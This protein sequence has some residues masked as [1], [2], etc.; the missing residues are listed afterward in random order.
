MSSADGGWCQ[1]S[2]AAQESGRRLGFPIKVGTASRSRTSVRLHPLAA[3]GETQRIRHVHHMQHPSYPEV[4][5]CGCVCAG[6]MESDYEGAQAREKGLRNSSA[7]RQQWLKRDWRTS[8][9]GNPFLN[10]DGYNVVVYLAGQGWG[11][12]VT[13]R[14]TDQ[15][16]S[17]RRSLPS[18]EAAKL[19][20]FDAMTWMKQ[21][22]K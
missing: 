5:E 8:R 18:M 6:H 14:G 11:F 21:T 22:G 3:C 7:R 13:N 16:L 1:R 4:L 2:H 19:R 9:S 20:A 17:S 15:G 12:R 10:S